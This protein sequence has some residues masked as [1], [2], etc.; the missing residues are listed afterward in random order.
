MKKNRSQIK[1]A[2]DNISTGTAVLE[3]DCSTV[4]LAIPSA[5]SL[6]VSPFSVAGLKTTM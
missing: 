2:R 3:T 6:I 5:Q 1:D 4:H